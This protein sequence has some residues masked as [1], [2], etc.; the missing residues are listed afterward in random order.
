MIYLMNYE[1]WGDYDEAPHITNI[2]KDELENLLNTKYSNFKTS[3]NTLHRC[4]ANIKHHTNINILDPTKITRISPWA[5]GNLHNLILSN[6]PLWSKF[7]KRNKSIIFDFNY[8][9][10]GGY[11]YILIP[12]NNAILG[13]CPVSDMWGAF[14]SCLNYF[15]NTEIYNILQTNCNNFNFDNDYEILMECINNIDIKNITYSDHRIYSTFI[16]P[17]KTLSEAIDNFINPKK[18]NFKTIKY[19][20][21]FNLKTKS[22]LEGWTESN[23]ILVKQSVLEELGY[24]F[25]E[26]V[27]W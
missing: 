16:K 14:P 11:H 19:T 8:S 24:N 9:T 12:E 23:C 7:P 15:F 6:S 10:H 2:N 13:V 27:N 17:Y 22:S 3:N 25:E 1:N 20:K 21:N 18:N 26:I 5:S 4:V